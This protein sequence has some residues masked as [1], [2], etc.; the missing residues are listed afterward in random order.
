[1]PW[2]FARGAVRLA[3]VLPISFAGLGVWV[4]SI[5]YSVPV[6]AGAAAGGLFGWAA[7]AFF[8]RRAGT[9]GAAGIETPTPQTRPSS[10]GPLADANRALQKLSSAIEQSA[11]SVLITNRHGTI[12]YVNPA[13]EA[14]TGFSRAEAIGA[15]PRLVSSGLQDKAFYETMWRTLLNGGAFRTVVTNKRKDGR[16]FT[17]DQTITPIRDADGVITHFVSTGRDITERKRIEAALRRLNAALEEESARIASVL[18]DEAGQFLSAAHITLADVARDLAPEHR[19]RVQEV[20]QHLDRAEEQLRR[21]SHEL[22][23]RILDDLGLVEAVRFLTHGFGRRTGMSVDVDVSATSCPRAVETVF[24]RLVQEGLTNIGK[25]AHATRV[26]VVLGSEAQRMV[27]AIRDDGVGFDVASTGEQR[28]GFSL[29][30]ALMRDR[31]EAVGGTLTI[32]S[33][34][35]HGSELRASVPMEV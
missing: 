11:D 20:R 24:Y 28:D 2:R 26:S 22:H 1:M 21:V 9:R 27:C 34:P 12:E 3:V 31:V 29:G 35:A 8:A 6:L 7:T 18:H 13:Y 25:H 4:A 14:M 23:P 16:L 30:L 32:V 5:F 17:E 33:I 10:V 15:N 19:A